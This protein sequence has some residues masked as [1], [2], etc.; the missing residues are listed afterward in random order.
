MKKYRVEQPPSGR[1]REASAGRRQL[2]GFIALITVA[3][4]AY[5][6]I[7]LTG[8]WRTAALFILL[9]A[10]IAIAMVLLRRDYRDAIDSAISSVVIFSLIGMVILPEG[11]VCWLL[12]LP[13]FI[14]VAVLVGL[15]LNKINSTQ[16]VV[17]LPLLLLAGT[18]GFMIPDVINPAN[19]ASATVVVDIDEATLRERLATP[20]SFDEQLPRVLRLGFPTPVKA[21]GAGLEPGDVRIIE[22]TGPNPTNPEQP[23]AMTLD[24]THVGDSYVRFA[25]AED[26]TMIGQWLTMDDAVITWEPTDDGRLQVNWTTTHTRRMHPGWYF[27]PLQNYAMNAAVDYLLHEIVAGSHVASAHG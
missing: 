13:I 17:L 20:P 24:V 25:M 21:T 16:A 9:P 27:D 22:F 2:A 6:L 19:L 3:S 26:T 8:A 10:G 1:W 23:P 18:E 7:Y 5:R 14:I 4:M 15:I 12:A 11:I